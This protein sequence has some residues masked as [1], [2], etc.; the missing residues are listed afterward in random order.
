MRSQINTDLKTLQQEQEGLMKNVFNLMYYGKMSYSDIQ[1]MP[2]HIRNKISDLLT[3]TVQ[4]E[5]KK[6]EEERRKNKK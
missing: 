1:I 3:E 6:I 5:N 2:I 4:E